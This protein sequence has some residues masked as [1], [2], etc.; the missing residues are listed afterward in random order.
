[1]ERRGKWFQGRMT[2]GDKEQQKKVTEGDKDGGEEKAHFLAFWKRAN[3]SGAQGQD[4]ADGADGG[5]VL[6]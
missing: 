2:E 5:L 4:Q 3:G 1:M 6:Q